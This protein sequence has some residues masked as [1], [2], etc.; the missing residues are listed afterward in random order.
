MG[1]VVPL[2]PDYH[3]VRLRV[4]V[5][6]AR[7]WTPMLIEG[8]TPFQWFAPT[9]PNMELSKAWEGLKSMRIQFKLGGKAKL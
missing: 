7:R 9:P 1:R 8:N 2:T 5:D 3:G 6:G 4:S